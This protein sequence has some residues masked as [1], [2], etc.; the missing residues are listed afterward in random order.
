[1]FTHHSHIIYTSFTFHTF[2]LLCI[3]P[4]SWAIGAQS[5]GRCCDARRG[6]ASTGGETYRVGLLNPK[7]HETSDF[8]AAHE[9][10]LCCDSSDSSCFFRC[11]V[12]IWKALAAVSLGALP[13]LLPMEAQQF[14]VS[15]SV[16]NCSITPKESKTVLRVADDGTHDEAMEVMVKGWEMKVCRI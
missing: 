8:E 4:A 2:Y 16:R 14:C 15:F 6:G 11:M 12:H 7:R 3:M 9:S 1:M 13:L 10:R 5:S